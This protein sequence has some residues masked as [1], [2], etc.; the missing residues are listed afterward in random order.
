MKKKLFASQIIGKPEDIHQYFVNRLFCSAHLWTKVPA[1]SAVI[2]LCT[3]KNFL[4]HTSIIL[5]KVKIPPTYTQNIGYI[6]YL[7]K[8]NCKSLNH[9]IEYFR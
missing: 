1:T 2:Q 7:K 6:I 4:R 5:W 3:I 9:S 8:M